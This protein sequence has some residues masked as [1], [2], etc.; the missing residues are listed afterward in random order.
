LLK[1]NL[2]TDIPTEFR[3]GRDF[4]LRLTIEADAMCPLGPFKGELTI[5]IE[6]EGKLLKQHVAI[7]GEIVP[8]VYSVPRVALIV[9]GREDDQQGSATIT[10]HSHRNQ[11]IKILRAWSEGESALEISRADGKSR[12]TN[13]EYRITANTGKVVPG[14]EPLKSMTFF[15]LADRTMVSVPTVIVASH[16]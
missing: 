9:R 6:A 2:G 14:G 16:Q 15:E 13:L 1:D 5:A 11:P 12:S 3:T 4:R 8:D 10:L 7:F